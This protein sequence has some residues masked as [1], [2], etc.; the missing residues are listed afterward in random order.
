MQ[1]LMNTASP[2]S[3]RDLQRTIARAAD[4][5]IAEIVTFVDSLPERG[6]AD[7]LLAP[8]R[9][10]LLHIRP[11]RRMGFSRLL[12]TPANTMVVSATHW[13]RNSVTIPRTALRCLAVQARAH[14]GPIAAGIDARFDA[15]IAGS[16][17]EDRAMILREGQTLWHLAADYFRSAELPDDWTS[18]TGL[19]AADHTA[20]ARPLATL[21]HVATTAEAFADRAGTGR[22]VSPTQIRDCLGDAAA[23]IGRTPSSLPPIGMLVGVLL[24]RLPRP[25]DVLVAAGDL[26]QAAADPSIRQA[27]DL[28]ID[29]LL[30][31]ST[32]ALADQ[33]DL[34]V[35]RQ[36]LERLSVLLDT[37]EQPGPACR[38]ARRSALAA[39]RR[40][41][42]ATCRQRFDAEITR[43]VQ[44]ARDDGESGATDVE[45]TLLEGDMRRLRRLE[46]TA[47]AFGGGPSYDR[48]ITAAAERLAH[49]S[50]RA[51]RACD[52]ARLIEI[53]DGP[54]AAL[55]FLFPPPAASATVPP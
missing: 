53:L 46:A 29:V 20:I 18:Q 1:P 27:S 39:L 42:D 25:E 28:A 11:Q 9:G 5:R 14:L 49:T 12:F 31:G 30:A 54:E 24:A 15:R 35:V 33:P 26:A 16:T 23:W 34:S 52:I 21:L 6:A 44:A 50:A 48:A 7:A 32:T 45:T 37:L 40:D 2:A 3:I 55:A 10:R 36:D 8:L 38:P 13:N 4:A 17:E 47:R 41:I 51:T 22:A 43:C 19:A